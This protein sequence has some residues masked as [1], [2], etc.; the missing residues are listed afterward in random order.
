M[1]K[2]LLI[3]DAHGERE[4]PLGGTVAV[5]RDPG[6][7]ISADDP[8][9]SRRHAEFVLTTAGVLVRD[10]KSRNGIRVNGASVLEANLKSGDTVQ[11]AGLSIRFVDDAPPAAVPSTSDTAGDATRLLPPPVARAAPAAAVPAAPPAEDKTTLI[12]SMQR[13]AGLGRPPTAAAA[14]IAR[15]SPRAAAAPAP[16]ASRQPRVAKTSWSARVLAQIAALAAV[17]FIATAVPLVLWEGRLVDATADAQATALVNWFAA[18]AALPLETGAPVTSAADVM[19]RE[20]GVV[21]AVVLSPQGRVLAPASRASETIATIPGLG[22]APADVL[23]ARSARND[24]LIEIA[25]PVAAK[26]SAR[27]AV[28]W[29]SYRPTAPPEAGSTAVVLAPAVLIALVGTFFVVAV[30]RR[31]TL[32]GLSML[33][34]DIELAVAGQIAEVGDP[35]GAKPVHDL[36]ATVNYLVTRVKASG[37]LDM[38]A[39]GARVRSDLVR[40][41]AAAGS[42]VVSSPAYRGAAAPAPAAAAPPSAPRDARVVANAKLRVTEVSGGVADLLGAKSNIVG[43][44]LLDA[45]PEKTVVDAVLKCLGAL[46]GGGE[47]RTVVS[48]DGKPYKLSVVVSRAGKDQPVTIVVKMLDSAGAA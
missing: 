35:L 28:V 36:A 3:R 32:R 20:P 17:V 33:N 19:A 29:L 6:C 44:H 15:Q 30:V 13:P 23:R 43:E 9:L 16:A 48:P 1:S 7:A 22:L 8:L 41:S 12:P 24:D 40:Q 27:A 34:E 45:I 18:E 42:Q 37:A 5:G 21:A 46:S 25:R 10:L 38:R 11:V 4:V 14:P 26:G 2:K 39:S 47:E 31:T